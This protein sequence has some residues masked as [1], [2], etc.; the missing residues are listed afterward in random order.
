MAYE[1]KT[2]ATSR[3]LPKGLPDATGEVKNGVPDG[4]VFELEDGSK[5]RFRLRHP[6]QL[7]AEWVEIVKRQKTEKTDAAK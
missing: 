2:S 1:T 5:R 3:E 4:A 7:P 6:R